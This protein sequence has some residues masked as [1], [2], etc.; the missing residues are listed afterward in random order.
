M[1]EDEKL[2]AGV[3]VIILAGLATVS[4]ITAVTMWLS[5]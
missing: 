1:N 2:M 4:V 3:C 5:N